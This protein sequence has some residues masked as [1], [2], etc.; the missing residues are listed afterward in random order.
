MTR[1]KRYV[2]WDIEARNGFV[3]PA[4]DPLEA[5]QTVL[6]PDKAVE[7]AAVEGGSWRVLGPN[8]ERAGHVYTRAS[9]RDCFIHQEA[10]EMP[11]FGPKKA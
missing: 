7:V 2:V 8:G 4:P 5:A 10:P 6:G 11:D 9:W 1:D 3:I